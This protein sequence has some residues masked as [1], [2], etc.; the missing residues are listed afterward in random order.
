M[1]RMV[2]NVLDR[3][4]APLSFMISIEMMLSSITD[5]MACFTLG[6]VINPWRARF[7]TKAS[8]EVPED[9]Q[10]MLLPF[11]R[12]SILDAAQPLQ[13]AVSKVIWIR[14]AIDMA[15]M[16]ATS[17]VRANLCN[18]INTFP[19]CLSSEEKPAWH[20]WTPFM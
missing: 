6:E 14:T 19:L 1:V 2:R 16:R 13:K 17:T 3:P 20:P 10:A 4:K 18:E 7:S 11:R 15:V 9:L 5:S 12:E 8:F